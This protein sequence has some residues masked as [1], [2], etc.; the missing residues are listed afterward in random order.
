MTKKDSPSFPNGCYEGL[1]KRELFAAMALQGILSCP[2]ETGAIPFG[3]SRGE[4]RARQ[5]V[6]HADY[7]IQALNED[8][9]ARQQAAQQEAAG[10]NVQGGEDAVPG[11]PEAWKPV[12]DDGSPF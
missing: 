4:H 5:A 11:V 12:E 8:E 1:T 9:H 6:K 7:L 10:A 2:V 3:M